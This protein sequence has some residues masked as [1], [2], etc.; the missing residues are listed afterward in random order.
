[1][2]LIIGH[3]EIYLAWV[4][5]LF[6]DSLPIYGASFV[7]S[8]TYLQCMKSLLTKL[9]YVL[10]LTAFTNRLAAQADTIPP[11]VKNPGIPNFSIQT[12]DS[13]WFVKPQLAAKKPT[14][15]LY[16]SPDCGHCQMETEEL[17]SRI[18]KLKQLQVV[19]I[20]SRPF[21]DMKNFYEFYKL[22]RYPTIKVGTDPNRVITTFYDVK[23]T[24]FSA[25]YDK[26]G[27]LI[28]AYEKGIDWTDFEKLVK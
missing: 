2:I 25:L 5:G 19:M 8:S 26:K 21:E 9:L 15:I 4:D 14:L 11:Y 24:P 7:M 22:D 16:F 27:K 10:L 18:K 6:Y 20:T 1:M 13:S 28:K 3:F 17:L 12:A 23:F